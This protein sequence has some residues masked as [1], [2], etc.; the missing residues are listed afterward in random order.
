MDIV[1]T[2][3]FECELIVPRFVLSELQAVADSA[4][5]LKR[6][7]GRRGI[8]ILNKLQSSKQ[9]DVRILEVKEEPGGPRTVDERLV[10]LAQTLNARIATTDDNLNRIAQL[11][12]VEAINVNDLANALKPV[13]LPGES[14]SVKIIKVGEEAGQGIGYLEDG[15]M[16]VVDGGRDRIGQTV[17][18]AVTS[19]L[20]TSAGRMVFGRI[21]GA[22]PDTSRKPARQPSATTPSEG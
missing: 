10:D 9:V 5:R 14:M 18:I 11:R 1:D 20:Q 15:T 2:R 8:E 4:D 12:G 7:R 13:C 6:N 19:S 3:I 17:A 16:V 21:E 22:P